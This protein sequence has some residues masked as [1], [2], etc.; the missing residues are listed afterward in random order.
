MVKVLSKEKWNDTEIELI[1]GR[2]Y[3]YN[4]NGKWIDWFI[5]CDADGYPGILSFSMDVFLRGIKRTPSAKWFRL[6]GVIDKNTSHTIDLGKTGTFTALEDGRLW[7]FA[8]DSNSAYWN[9]CGSIEL[10]L[11]ELD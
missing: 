10:E 7:V 6:V 3:E 9:N 8:N 11:K 1:K 5:R 4:A 2:N